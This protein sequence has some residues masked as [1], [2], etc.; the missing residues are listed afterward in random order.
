[1]A[2]VE[3]GLQVAAAPARRYLPRL[4]DIT[5][6]V[7]LV[8]AFLF[9]VVANLASHNRSNMVVVAAD[10]VS[11]WF[12]LT[13]GP[14]KSVSLSPYD[15]MLA[16]VGTMGVMLARPGG[17]ALIGP[18]LTGVLG[19]TGLGIAI[20]AKLSINRSF[21]IGPANRGIKV[22]GAYAFIRHPMYLGYALVSATYLLLNPTLYNASIYGLTWMCQIGRIAR[23]E[24]WLMR[25]P[26]YRAYARVVRFRLVPGII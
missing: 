16:L 22:G 9:Y 18:V 19:F 8:A 3:Q 6:R 26:A 1:M 4:L 15:L 20:A 5:E 12:V 25:D 13:R 7:M 21:G 2:I 14:A 10:A 23:E 24:D 11:V 17:H